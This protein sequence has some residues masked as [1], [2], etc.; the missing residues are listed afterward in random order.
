[1]S[2]TIDGDI[3]HRAA[4][5]DWVQPSERRLSETVCAKLMSIERWA[6]ELGP[7]AR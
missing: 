2:D 1:M 5:S 7:V 6:S 3:P 4:S